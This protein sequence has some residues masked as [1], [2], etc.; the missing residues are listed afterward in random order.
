MTV[1]TLPRPLVS[2]PRAD[3]RLLRAVHPTIIRA[4]PDGVEGR[5][6][7]DVLTYDVLDDYDTEFAPGVF[8][9]SMDER[10]PRIVWGHDWRQV[11]GRWTKHTNVK[12]G[13]RQKLR[14]VGELDDFDAVPMARQAWAQLQS[15]TIDQFSV[16]FI[17][18]ELNDRE[19]PD[20]KRMVRRFVRG[21]L[22]EVSLVL[23]GAVPETALVGVRERPSLRLHVREPLISKE[24]AAAIML[25]L[26]L[27][28][29]DLADALAE[30][31]GLPAEGDSD[32]KP[33]E[34]PS[35]AADDE[36]G[37]E[38]PDDTPDASDGEGAASDEVPAD[39]A[40][41]DDTPAA[42]GEDIDIDALLAEAD[43]VLDRVDVLA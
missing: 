18:E 23:V 26:H 1:L 40:T 6:T 4:T 22:D 11:L 7:A 29:I 35:D 36:P 8:D 3:G 21:R 16:G 42:E 9:A 43:E 20:L 30:V 15:G 37:T 34:P 12:V 14:L 28:E 5:F 24:Q 39:D 25:R 32:D 38:G 31:K 33:A 2:A 27:G 10:M 13:D 19:D 17:P 41:A